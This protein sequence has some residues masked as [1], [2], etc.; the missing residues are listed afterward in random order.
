[1]RVVYQNGKIWDVVPEQ[2]DTLKELAV[3]SHMTVNE[4]INAV[5]DLINDESGDNG[6]HQFSD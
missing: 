2:Q 5:H 4:L 6:N 1:M 3:Y